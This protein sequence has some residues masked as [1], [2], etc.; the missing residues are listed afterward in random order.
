MKLKKRWFMLN[1]IKRDIKAPLDR[2]KIPE[3]ITSKKL[4]YYYF[5]FEENRISKGK[6]QHL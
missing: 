2:Y 6:D 3:N 5:K 4:G 1:K